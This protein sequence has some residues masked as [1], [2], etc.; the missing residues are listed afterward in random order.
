MKLDLS[1]MPAAVKVGWDTG[2]KLGTAL[3]DTF[4]SVPTTTTPMNVP[5][6][7]TTNN[8][9]ND[10]HPPFV[11]VP[12]P[13]TK[14]IPT[15]L[16]KDRDTSLLQQGAYK[17]SD[18]FSGPKPDVQRQGERMLI[19][20]NERQVMRDRFTANHPWVPDDNPFTLT[21]H[22]LHRQGIIQMIWQLLKDAMGYVVWNFHDLS[23]YFTEQHKGVWSWFDLSHDV[24]FLWRLGVSALIAIGAIQL[25]GLADSVVRLVDGLMS[26]LERVFGLGWSSLNRIRSSVMGMFK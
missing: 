9:S 5:V 11:P 16:G 1:Y 12:P 25:V 19:D 15:Y 26:I 3:R 8:N 2:N 22:D 23:H 10:K 17:V 14:P 7:V 6:V 18:A 13:P 20:N 4:V 21:T 24:S